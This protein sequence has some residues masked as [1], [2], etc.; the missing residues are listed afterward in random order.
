[1]S[2]K[3]L[4]TVENFGPYAKIPSTTLTEEERQS[5]P[6]SQF[7]DLP[8]N[9]PSEETIRALLP[10]NEIDPAIAIL[11][12]ECAKLFAPG[13]LECENGY[14]VLPQGFGFSAVKI[15]MP[16][17]KP[18]ML[19]FWFPWYLS[20]T[21]HYKTWLPDMHLEMRMLERGHAATE[22]L[23]WGPELPLLGAGT[24][25]TP[26]DFGIDNPTDCDP[27]FFY[28]F[29]GANPIISPDD[30]LDAV[31]KSYLTMINYVRRKGTGLEWRVRTWIGV[32][33]RN[34]EYILDTPSD[35][36]VPLIDRVRGMACHNAWEWSRMAT[37]LPA[38]YQF[39]QENGLEAP[40]PRA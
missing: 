24:M 16:E 32:N 13:Y 23:G 25:L 10:G 35:D 17:V 33:Y 5:T 38:I 14:C 9:L 27:D 30:S 7:F 40:S 26:A 20:S 29:G 28:F 4:I 21:V 22:D 31:P 18:E 36:A 34:G 19:N 37:L 1:M 15:D 11:P 2:Y 39:A 8:I 6:Y 12:E 3:E